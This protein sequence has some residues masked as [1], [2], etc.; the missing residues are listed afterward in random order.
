MS[1]RRAVSPAAHGT[2]HQRRR[3]R[4][5]LDRNRPRL[6][7]RRCYDRGYRG[8]HR[9]GRPCGR[10][11]GRRRLNHLHIH[12][13]RVI[14]RR[15]AHTGGIDAQ[16]D[17]AFF[18]QPAHHERIPGNGHTPVAHSQKAPDIHHGGGRMPFLVQQHVDHLPHMVA[19]RRH[20]VTVDQAAQP[21]RGC[22]R[23]AM[24]LLRSGRRRH[25]QGRR[26]RC[27]QFGLVTGRHVPRGIA[28]KAP[29]RRAS[30]HRRHRL[31]RARST[32]RQDEKN[33]QR[34]EQSRRTHETAGRT[35]DR[36]QGGMFHPQ[37]CA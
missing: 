6:G 33:R 9:R 37:S 35:R 18:R 31:R 15:R 11:R 10:G 32:G 21:V 7:F 20:H 5:G 13:R 16:F 23:R 4:L 30:R 24:R 19:I 8:R 1:L 36:G 26:R 29:P 14:S 17:R 12:R 3:R 28:D 27:R 2:G 25:Q 22:G 34:T